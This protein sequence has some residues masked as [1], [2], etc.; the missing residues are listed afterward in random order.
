MLIAAAVRAP[1]SVAIALFTLAV[2]A[3]SLVNSLVSR[4]ASGGW[5]PEAQAQRGMHVFERHCAACHAVRGTLAQ[6]RLG[7]DLTHVGS[8]LTIGAGVLPNTK[9]YLGGWVANPQGIKP[10]SQM[11][12]VPLEAQDFRALLIYLQ[13]LS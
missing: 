3:A 7:P 4:L 9:G 13:G 10:G 2:S 11:P 6:G 12:Y 8:R 1:T 5:P